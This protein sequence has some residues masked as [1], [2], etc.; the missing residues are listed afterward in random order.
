LLVAAL[1]RA[2]LPVLR[3]REP[4]GA[5]GA[6]ELRELLLNGDVAWSAPAE[7]LLHFAARAEHVE[8]TIRPALAAGM[9]VVC[10]RFADSTMVYQGWGQGADRAAIATL[11]DMLGLRPD[12]TLVLDV[13]VETSLSRLATRGAAADRY[14]RLGADFFGRIRAGFQAVAAADP[15]RCVVI[16]A[17]ASEG[18]VAYAIWR[19]VQSRFSCLSFPQQRENS[20]AS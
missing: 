11:T 4:G 16:D 18:A 3:T 13:S 19:V 7:T 20:V 10:D 8:R 9:W 5:P 14:E 12:L 17:E 1:A 2:G 15:G 6:E